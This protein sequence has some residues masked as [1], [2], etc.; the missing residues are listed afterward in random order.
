MVRIRLTVLLAA[1]VCATQAGCLE[2]IHRAG[3]PSTPYSSRTATSYD[4]GVLAGDRSKHPEVQAYMA[5]LDAL[6]QGRQ[7]L[8][9]GV[10][11]H[12]VQVSVLPPGMIEPAPT[13]T[14]AGIVAAGAARRRVTIPDIVAPP[15]PVAADPVPPTVSPAVKAEP[16]PDAAP[17]DADAV[18]ACIATVRAQAAAN[19]N[20]LDLQLQLRL[21]LAAAGRDDEATQ[22][23]GGLTADENKRVGDL[24]R[25]IMALRDQTD[26]SPEEAGARLEAL[27][28]F[29]DQLRAV[30]D[31]QIPTARLCKQVDGYGVYVPFEST[32]FIAGHTQPVIVYCEVRN[33][34]TE[35]DD[36]G[37]F[38]T[39]L[40]MQFGLYDAAGQLAQPIE[41]NSG[42]EDVSANRRHDFFLRGIYFLRD[43]LK[44]GQYTLKVTIEDPRANKAKTESIPITLVK[45]S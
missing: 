22:P 34:S 30:A 20:D 36:T 21:L 26:P 29:G 27:E 11:M 13:T 39:Q 15:A 28:Y 14:N 16:Q 18:N 6:Q 19:P 5:R 43:D 25:M 1:L 12:P 32:T 8:N 42:I 17:L 31:L 37:M 23:I 9:E 3:Q 33:F 35:P 40:N 4:G 2:L 44:P 38:R 24:L 7:N 41:V 10:P 45:P